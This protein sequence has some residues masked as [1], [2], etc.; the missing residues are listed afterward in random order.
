VS[1]KKA[2]LAGVKS[3]DTSDPGVIVFHFNAPYMGFASLI[4]SYTF[5]CAVTSQSY[6]NSVGPAVANTAPIGTGPYKFKSQSLD[7]IELTAVNPHWR[8]VPQYANLTFQNIPL[9]STAV[10]LLQTGGTD[11][12]SPDIQ[13]ASK[14]L[15]DKTYKTFTSP[16]AYT[17]MLLF[18][19]NFVPSDKRYSGP[20]PYTNVLVREAL[21]IAIDRNAIV[22]TIYK[23]YA[24]PARLG[25]FEPAVPSSVQP[26]PYNPKK[27]KAL[28][29]AAGYPN[30][31]PI[32]LNS[33]PFSP[34]VELPSVI[35]IVAE[36]WAAIG[37]QPQIVVGQYATFRPKWFAGQIPGQV[38]GISYPGVVAGKEAIAAQWYA[39]NSVLGIYESDAINGFITQWL[40][41]KDPLAQT[42]MAATFTKQLYNNYSEI[43]IASVDSVWISKRKKIQTYSPP[44]HWAAGYFEYTVQNPSNKTPVHYTPEPA[45]AWQAISN[46]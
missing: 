45:T 23:G 28:L 13:S 5:N 29:A 3:I 14:I 11:L 22:K 27:A 40:A 20:Q 17:L 10:D 43:G 30:G 36:Y 31:F 21:N 41:N 24:K 12:I 26:Y 35:E 8:V 32:I 37:I 15:G 6:Y 46:E 2:L 18:G 25:I 44:S 4:S 16:G 39:T 33:W 9:A 7:T 19:N 38:F 34:G 42:S 1:T